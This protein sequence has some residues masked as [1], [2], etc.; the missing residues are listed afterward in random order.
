MKKKKGGWRGEERRWVAHA[1]TVM[2]GAL[3]CCFFNPPPRTLFFTAFGSR[4]REIGR[5]RKK[6]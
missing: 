3:Q 4:G 5:E 2:Q 1:I 6:H